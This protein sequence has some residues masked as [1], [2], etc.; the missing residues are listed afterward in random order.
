MSIKIYSPRLA[1][2]PYAMGFPKGSMRILPFGRRRANLFAQAKLYKK[3]KNTPRLAAGIF[4]WQI[5]PRE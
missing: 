3:N 2:E 4:I 1:A 5:K